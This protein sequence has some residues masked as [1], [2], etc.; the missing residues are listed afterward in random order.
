MVLGLGTGNLWIY[1]QGVSMD[2]DATLAHL[3]YHRLRAEMMDYIDSQNIDY[4]QIGTAFPN[5]N[6]GED[7]LLNGDPRKC[8]EKDF[9]KNQYVLLSNIYNDFSA[10]DYRFFEK[11]WTLI[12]RLKQSGVWIN[13]Y[14]KNGTKIL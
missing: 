8:V 6:T 13:L 7:L 2:W 4:A 3:P 12:K 1:P 14:Q 10:A 5:I 9:L 11:N